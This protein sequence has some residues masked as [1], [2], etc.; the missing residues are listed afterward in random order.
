MRKKKWLPNV[1]PRQIGMLYLSIIEIKVM[2]KKLIGK[3]ASVNQSPTLN[4]K[5]VSVGKSCVWEVT[6]NKYSNRGNEC[7]GK[8]FSLPLSISE[9]CFYGV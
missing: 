8:T 5:L 2:L 6:P 3:E 9:N 4:A 1:W 7:V